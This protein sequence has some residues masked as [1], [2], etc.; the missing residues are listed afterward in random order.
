[1]CHVVQNTHRSGALEKVEER[2]LE[3]VDELTRRSDGEAG[4]TSYGRVC[5]E[6]LGRIVHGKPGSQVIIPVEGDIGGREVEVLGVVRPLD[7]VE[8]GPD[9]RM[10]S[11]ECG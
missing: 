11:T 6:L 1:M 3:S 7:G 5:H 10:E 4:R 8:G 2:V 9:R